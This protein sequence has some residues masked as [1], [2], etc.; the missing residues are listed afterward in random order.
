[1]PFSLH[2]LHKIRYAFAARSLSLGIAGDI[3]TPLVNIVWTPGR[4]LSAWPLL[5]ALPDQAE[6]YY[7]MCDEVEATEQKYV[8]YRPYNHAL[9]QALKAWQAKQLLLEACLEQGKSTVVGTRAH[10]MPRQSLAVPDS[11]PSLAAG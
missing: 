10:Y 6:D 7:I 4:W 11:T 1:M 2:C 8:M 3:Y 5:D 9:V